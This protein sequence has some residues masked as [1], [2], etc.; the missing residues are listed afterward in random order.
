M[1]LL[2]YYGGKQKYYE[3]HNYK[4]S[5]GWKL[6]TQQKVNKGRFNAL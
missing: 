5:K 6:N 2:D 4:R 3:A 1:R